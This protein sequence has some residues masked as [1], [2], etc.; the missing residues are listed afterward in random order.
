MSRPAAVL[1]ALSAAVLALLG[2]CA[3]GP[4]A[5][6]TGRTEHDHQPPTPGTSSSVPTSASDRLTPPPTVAPRPGLVD[7]QVLPWRLPEPVGREAAVPLRA[8]IVVAG[9]LVAGDRSTARTYRLDLRTGRTT[10]LPDLGVPVHDVGGA[11]LPRRTVAVIGGGNSTEQDVVQSASPW[12]RWQIQ[13]H[14]PTPRSDL[15]AVSSGSRVF[16]IGGYD[17]TTP[18]LAEILVGS[19]PAGFHPFGQLR[20]P[21]RYP[22]AA[23]LDGAIWVLGGE[24]SGAEVD[25]V[26]RI[27]LGTGEVQ[28]T[29]KLPEPL[30]HASAVAFGGRILLLGGRTSDSTP[31]SAMWWFDPHTSRFHRAG[32]LPTPLADSA[33]VGG[34]G[35]AYLVGGETPGLSDR[36]LRVRA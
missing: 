35:V 36:V 2:S 20:V 12:G 25:T 23:L 16:V 1:A 27:D 19:G 18:A 28:V 29:A 4:A 5:D 21:V 10:A 15:V 30:G 24:R 14:L 33:V 13:G 8:G 34:P 3:S 11:A 31:T 7:V 9:G 6:P 32:S 22:A 17:G 26:Q